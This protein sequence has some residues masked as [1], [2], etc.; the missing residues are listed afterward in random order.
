M[1]CVGGWC[2][3]A[4]PGPHQN[5][6]SSTLSQIQAC[7]KALKQTS[8]TT[9]KKDLVASLIAQQFDQLP[10]TPVTIAVKDES[11]RCVIQQLAKQAGMTI[12]LDEG[13]SGFVPL[14]MAQE[15]PYSHVLKSLLQGK[16]LGVVVEG[17]HVRVAKKTV[18]EKEFRENVR[19][20]K[21]FAH[22][23]CIRIKHAVWNEVFTHRLKEMW[24]QCCRQY[25]GVAEAQYFFCDDATRSLLLQGTS[26]QIRH[27]EAFVRAL[28]KPQRQVAIHARLVLASKDFEQ[29]F[30]TDWLLAMQGQGD[31]QLHGSLTGGA[32]KT[33]EVPI[34]LGGGDD[35]SKRLELLLNAAE[36]ANK[37]RTLLKPSLVTG[38][39]QQAELLEGRSVP[40]E[41][42]IEESV[43]GKTRSTRSAVYKDVGIKLRVKPDISCDGTRVR[44]TVHVENSHLEATH[45]KYPT[46]I[47]TRAHT[48][49]EVRSGQTAMLGGLLKQKEQEKQKQVPFLGSLP[50]IGHLFS[51]KRSFDEKTQLLIFLRP[52]VVSTL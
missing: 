26:D 13:V 24:L 34:V 6:I 51:G 11:F 19:R 46:I 31:M 8:Q 9:V 4:S 33:L 2:C 1:F 49:L 5:D 36:H 16:K 12:T 38:D 14:C 3:G 45:E 30:G 35:A 43:E 15:T 7:T 17:M 21:G 18:L 47:T 25:P 44:L 52:S 39:R 28:D 20:G 42:L 22:A 37:V 48:T 41:S 27:F 10:L 32:S 40:I 29:S 50:L 23:R